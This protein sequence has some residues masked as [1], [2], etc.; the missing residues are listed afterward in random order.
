MER[1]LSCGSGLVVKLS[2]LL[3]IFWL[4]QMPVRTQ[5]RARDVVQVDS[6]ETADDTPRTKAWNLLEEGAR[7]KTWEKRAQ[8][9]RALGVLGAE[10]KAVGLAEA[11]LADKEADVRAAAASVLGEMGS[12]RSEPKLVAATADGKISVALAAAHSLLALNN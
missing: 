11:G 1:Q 12:V 6:R 4:T 10:P 3:V 9:I 7:E 8:T 5:T 2:W